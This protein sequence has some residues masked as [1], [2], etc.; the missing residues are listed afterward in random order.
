L[1]LILNSK[2][3]RARQRLLAAFLTT[4]TLAKK[5]H[6]FHYRVTNDNL[7]ATIQTGH[8]GGYKL[9]QNGTKRQ[10]KRK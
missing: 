9:D 7:S 5:E 8:L 3:D 1:S 6:Q 4:D 10:Q 2:N